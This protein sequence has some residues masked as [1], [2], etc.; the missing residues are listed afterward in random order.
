MNKL[1]N[2]VETRLYGAHVTSFNDMQQQLNVDAN[3]RN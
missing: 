3:R 2:R 1:L